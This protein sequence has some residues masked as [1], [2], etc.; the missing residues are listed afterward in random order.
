VIQSSPRHP[1]RDVALLSSMHADYLTEHTQRCANYLAED[2]RTI[3]LNLV[4]RSGRVRE[5][6]GAW[7][8]CV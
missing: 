6:L 5:V 7:L 2:R 4:V 8:I 1:S 3:R